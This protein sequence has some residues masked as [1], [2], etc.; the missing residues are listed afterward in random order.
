MGT[1]MSPTIILNT[2]VPQGSVLSPVLY[3]RY[4]HDCNATHRSNTLIKFAD[5]T[6]II[7]LIRNDDE[8]PNREEVQAITTWCSDNH[9]NLNTKKTK[10]VIIR[11][12]STTPHSGLRINGEE[13]EQAIIFKCFGL[14]ISEDLGWNM[15]TTHIINP[16][17]PELCS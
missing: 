2:G 16:F 14:H 3:T 1:S 10:E 13:E 5:H 17:I 7:G 4:T 11:K 6:T 9:L 8:A 15:N 12:A